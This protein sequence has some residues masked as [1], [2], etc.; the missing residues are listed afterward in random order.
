MV[1]LRA[2]RCTFPSA[3][4]CIQSRKSHEQSA[5]AFI[6]Q[7]I[8]L[9]IYSKEMQ[10]KKPRKIVANVRCAW[11]ESLE[12]VKIVAANEIHSAFNWNMQTATHM[13]ILNAKFLVGPFLSSSVWQKFFCVTTTPTEQHNYM[14]MMIIVAPHSIHIQRCFISVNAM[15]S[16]V[17]HG[18]NE[19]L[20]SSPPTRSVNA[21]TNARTRITNSNNWN[22]LIRSTH[23]IV[24][25]KFHSQVLFT[26]LYIWE[27][28][29]L[30]RY[31]HFI[32]NS[33]LYFV[34]SSDS[35]MVFANWHLQQCHVSRELLRMEEVGFDMI[36]IIIAKKMATHQH[37]MVLNWG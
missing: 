35:C 29:R 33:S 2:I 24:S 32:L 8:L 37:Q 15:Q 20:L 27:R 18:N 26:H 14:Q 28:C 10:S 7:V 19:I 31:N 34:I 11:C 21:Q 30:T 9:Q 25:Q 6:S 22:L 1:S 12:R 36:K 16:N 3:M 13:W 5:C 23:H 4:M 17:I